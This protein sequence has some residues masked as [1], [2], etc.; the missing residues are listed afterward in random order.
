[1]G[2]VANLYAGN[3]PCPVVGRISMDTIGVDVSDIDEPIQSLQ[4][5]NERHGIDKIAKVASTI[6]YEILTSL[7]SR[8]QRHYI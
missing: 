2:P 6:G 7:G 3:I 4:F 1:M 5:I 8:Y